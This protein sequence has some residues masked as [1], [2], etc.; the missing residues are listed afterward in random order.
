SGQK[1]SSCVVRDILENVSAWYRSGMPF[2]IAT[3]VETWSSAPRT[4]GASMAV[5]KDGDV[6]GSVSGGCV[7][8]AVFEL[9]QEVL[10][11][12]IPMRETYGVSDGDAF[13]IGLTCGGTLEIFIEL[14]TPERFP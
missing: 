5:S 12:G 3:V 2:A 9:C 11:T 7:E 1:E 10:T 4:A 14:I 6:I 13:S 8:G